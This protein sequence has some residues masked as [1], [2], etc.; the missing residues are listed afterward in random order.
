[1]GGAG[2]FRL[3]PRHGDARSV[4]QE[5]LPDGSVG[6]ELGDVVGRGGLGGNGLRLDLEDAE[7]RLGS[8]VF[9]ERAFGESR[10]GFARGDELAGKLDEIGREREGFDDVVDEVRRAAEGDLVVELFELG[11]V[12]EVDA[13][14]GGDLGEPGVR[15]T[16]VVVETDGEAAGGDLSDFRFGEEIA[17]VGLVFVMR[18]RSVRFGVEK[19]GS[20]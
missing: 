16:E 8:E 20:G 18:G 17:G 6:G 12:F 3:R 7:L 15:G 5:A 1:M 10:A 11:G 19:G 4:E 2:A 14:R 13:G 9:A